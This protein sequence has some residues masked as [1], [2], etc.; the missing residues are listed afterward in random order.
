[1]G[2]LPKITDVGNGQLS[3]RLVLPKELFDVGRLIGETYHHK[4]NAEII[5]IQILVE[6]I[7]GLFRAGDL[8]W[9]GDPVIIAA[10]ER[11]K[12]RNFGQLD[13]GRINVNLLHR[14]KKLKSGYTGVYASNQG[15]RAMATQPNNGGLK[16]IG[17]YPSA[18]E[19]A[20]ARREYH[21]V[22]KVPYG[23]LEIEIATWRKNYPE[24]FGDDDKTLIQKIDEHARCCGTWN[25][26]FGS[27]SG[28]II[29]EGV[30]DAPLEPPGL[31]AVDEFPPPAEVLNKRYD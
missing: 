30:L 2:R 11:L 10:I 29:P 12:G 23:E 15:F 1:M 26:I 25:D 5:G 18:E 17:T 4:R 9:L 24:C 27:G 31:R 19:A 21:I 22:N 8:K 16:N 6:R 20:W 14:S 13:D 28:T 3:S 7:L